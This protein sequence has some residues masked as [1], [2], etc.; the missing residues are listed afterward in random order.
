MQSRIINPEITP[1]KDEILKKIKELL[2][3]NQK[4]L[5][6]ITKFITFLESV[7]LGKPQSHLVNKPDHL[8]M[9]HMP[10]TQLEYDVIHYDFK[11]LLDILQSKKIPQ[12]TSKLLSFSEAI[13]FA[14][15][16]NNQIRIFEDFINSL[17]ETENEDYVMNHQEDVT[18]NLA[19]AIRFYIE[20][21]CRICRINKD[22]RM[23]ITACEDMLLRNMR[24]Y[25]MRY[26]DFKEMAP[27]VLNRNIEMILNESQTDFGRNIDCQEDSLITEYYSYRTKKK[28][29]K[30]EQYFDEILENLIRKSRR[31]SISRQYIHRCYLFETI[32]FNSP[33]FIK[34]YVLILPCLQEVWLPYTE[35]KIIYSNHSEIVSD[36]HY[37]KLPKLLSNFTFVSFVE[38]NPQGARNLFASFPPLRITD[39]EAALL[40]APAPPAPSLPPPAPAPA[41]PAPSLPPPAPAPP[42]LPPP[43]PPAPLN[44]L[45]TPKKESLFTRMFKDFQLFGGR[46]RK[47]RKTSKKRHRKSKYKKIKR[48]GIKNNNNNFTSRIRFFKKL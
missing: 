34:V 42:L 25:L 37:Y 47:T 17:V 13:P 3:S 14:A 18:T 5:S 46:G 39:E 27:E 9:M 1:L 20:N 28:L 44:M 19:M 45:Q 22:G 7:Y 43:A 48:R 41:P 2:P 40:P 33:T 26:P 36:I 30:N 12:I 11:M 4:E 32:L 29:G 35:V 8:L 24:E 38:T 15:C 6:T 23:T 31:E 21:Q 10:H 16:I